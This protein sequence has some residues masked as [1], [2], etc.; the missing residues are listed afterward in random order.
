MKIKLFIVCIILVLESLN[1]IGQNFELAQKEID[2][3]L[4]RT[5]F[6]DS[7]Y[8][9]HNFTS[10]FLLEAVKEKI[11]TQNIDYGLLNA[12]IFF[13]M[14]EI[15]HNKRR[16]ELV[17][18]SRIR[19]AAFYHSI[20][21]VKHNFFSHLNKKDTILYDINSRLRFF[22]VPIGQPRVYY[23]EILCFLDLVD[24]KRGKY[25]FVKEQF[26]FE[27]EQSIYIPYYVTWRKRLKRKVEFPTY[28]SLARDAIYLWMK[29][30]PHR[31]ILLDTSYQFAGT[32]VMIHCHPNSKKKLPRA[33]VTACL[34]KDLSSIE[35]ST[36][37]E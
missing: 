15:R 36:R 30:K 10:F 34:K 18:D 32:G 14:N 16:S 9:H 12:A 5:A 2:S 19:D 13:A 29:S 3:L 31:R 4:S 6:P 17:F 24:W 7:L 35:I 21:M 8:Q 33:K 28:E 20:Q 1:A 11:D 27:K 23:G 26:R 25:R 22:N 37:T